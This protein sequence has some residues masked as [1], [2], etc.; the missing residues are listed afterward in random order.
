[1]SKYNDE[2]VIGSSTD[3]GDKLDCLVVNGN[4]TSWVRLVV[5]CRVESGTPTFASVFQRDFP[6]CVP[7]S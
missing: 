5:G 4:V 6:F 3:E 7:I 2:S 1:M